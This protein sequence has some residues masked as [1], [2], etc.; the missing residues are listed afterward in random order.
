MILMLLASAC[1]VSTDAALTLDS[2]AVQDQT[3]GTEFATEDDDTDDVRD[4]D[5]AGVEGTTDG[6]TSPPEESDRGSRNIDDVGGAED[7][8]AGRISPLDDETSAAK[9]PAASNSPGGEIDFS[10]DR[11][12]VDCDADELNSFD[13]VFFTTAHV[14]VDGNLG[15]V[16]LGEPDEELL[17]AWRVLAEITPPGQLA[18]LGLFGGYASTEIDGT[19]LAFVNTLDSPGS[20]FQMSI[21]LEEAENDPDELMLT[22]A[23]EFAHVFTSL[24][25][26]TDRSVRITNCETYHNTEGCFREDSLMW[27]WIEEFWGDGLIDEINPWLTPTS[28]DGE[29]RCSINPGFLGSYAASNPEEDFAETFSGFV[30]RLEVESPELQAKMDWMAEQPGLVEFRDRA[31]AAGLGPL[32]NFFERCG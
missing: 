3:S 15:A 4:S 20:L 10:L 11:S 29:P 9:R 13:G 16:C 30:F 14:V 23:H 22:M 2:S 27:L 31:I 1:R 17:I 28:S 5:A 21:N 26:E 19:T 8:P 18:D 12:D 25:T 32:G 7:P 24:S 6:A